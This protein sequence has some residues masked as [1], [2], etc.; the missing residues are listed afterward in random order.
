MASFYLEVV[1]KG[2]I[3]QHL[4]ECVVIRVLANVVQV[5]MLSASTDTFLSVEGALQLGH[6]RMRIHGAEENSFV[7]VHARVCE[8][9]G[10]V[11][12]WNGRR[13][14]DECMVFRAEEAEELFS[15]PG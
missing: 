9:Q 10:W 6:I 12:V 13:G 4:E 14:G 7:L 11:I 15:D 8:E 5:I 1:T 3:A 2:P